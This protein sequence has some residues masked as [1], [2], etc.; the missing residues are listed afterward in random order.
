MN[1]IKEFF[2][3]ISYA[4]VESEFSISEMSMSPIIKVDALSNHQLLMYIYIYICCVP[5]MF[6]PLCFSLLTSYCAMRWSH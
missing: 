4:I 3:A 2:L 5:L 1:H 6:I